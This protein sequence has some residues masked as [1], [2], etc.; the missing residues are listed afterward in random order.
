MTLDFDRGRCRLQFI[1]MQMSEVRVAEFRAAE[2]LAEF[3][4]QHAVDRIDDG[5]RGD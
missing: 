1:G 3:A 2:Y 5:R 4:S